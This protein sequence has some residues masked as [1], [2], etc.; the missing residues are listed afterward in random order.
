MASI[1]LGC[2][3]QT[4]AMALK[5]PSLKPFPSWMDLAWKMMRRVLQAASAMSSFIDPHLRYRIDGPGLLEEVKEMLGVHPG[6]EVEEQVDQWR[7]RGRERQSA[8]RGA[9]VRHGFQSFYESCLGDGRR[10]RRSFGGSGGRPDGN[11]V[12]EDL[13]ERGHEKR[14]ERRRERPI[15]C[16]TTD[17]G[18][19][20]GVAAVIRRRRHRQA[21]VNTVLQSSEAN[22]ERV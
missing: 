11:Q 13:G 16:S 2:F 21:I 4:Q 15:K 14:K 20:R 5:K 10:S 12:V 7:V 19:R 22:G 6:R 17:M 1:V 3:S 9:G 8:F 18:S